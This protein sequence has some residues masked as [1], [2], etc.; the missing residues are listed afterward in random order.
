M[1]HPLASVWRLPPLVRR[2]GIRPSGSAP[3]SAG[4]AAVKPPADAWRRMDPCRPVS[5]HGRMATRIRA[6]LLR[7]HPDCEHP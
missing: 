2:A 3:V 7:R 6:T 4:R 1:E 5:P